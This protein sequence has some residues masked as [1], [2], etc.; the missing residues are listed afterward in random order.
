MRSEWKQGRAI[1]RGRRSNACATGWWVDT[2]GGE[3]AGGSEE[4]GRR[5][6]RVEMLGGGGD[7]LNALRRKTLERSAA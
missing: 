3:S 6:N 5:D 4:D 2:Y 7:G 1:G